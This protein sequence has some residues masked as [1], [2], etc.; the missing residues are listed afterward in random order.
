MGEWIETYR[1]A[2]LGSE[3]DP[4]AHMNT[5]LYT[6]RFDQATWFLLSS[7]GITPPAMKKRKRRVA[8][9]RQNLELKRELKGGQLVVVKSGFISVGDKYLRFV[10]RMLDSVTGDMIATDDCTAVEA[11]L[12]T[13][14]S[15]PLPAAVSKVARQHVV[16]RQFDE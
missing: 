9:T 14:R 1:G 8:V 5:Q 2:V 3:Y 6:T 13:G 11:D 15:S 4:E 10:H 12:K 7:I 16:T